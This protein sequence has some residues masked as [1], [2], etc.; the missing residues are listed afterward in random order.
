MSV[1]FAAYRDHPGA[2]INEIEKAAD[3]SMYAE[4]ARYYKENGIE[5]R[6]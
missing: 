1:G 5:R 6:R 2:S 4:K 3:D